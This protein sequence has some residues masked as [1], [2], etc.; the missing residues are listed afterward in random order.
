[1]KLKLSM[2][3][4]LS[5]AIAA[6]VVGIGAQTAIAQAN[7]S[8]CS[9]M[10]VSSA[11]LDRSA[12]PARS[13]SPALA[14]NPVAATVAKSGQFVAAEHPTQGKAQIVVENGK[15]YLKLDQAFATDDGPD[16]FVLLHRE[17]MPQSYS[18]TSYVNLGRLQN[19]KGEQ[20]YAI[21]D[22]VNLDEFQSAVIWCR[23]FSAT[24]GYAPLNA[25]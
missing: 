8:N 25:M 2:N 16:L 24:F 20:R 3:M 11:N 17:S 22:D 9:R 19:I 4:A 18:D 15:R 23:Q 10:T 1:M 5:A 21:P 7:P 6:T 14:A 13:A 12:N